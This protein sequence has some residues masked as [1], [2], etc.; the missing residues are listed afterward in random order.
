MLIDKQYQSIEED[1]HCLFSYANSACWNTIRGWEFSSTWVAA[2]HLVLTV[3]PEVWPVENHCYR[4]LWVVTTDF[5]LLFLHILSHNWCNG[6]DF[7][8]FLE[9]N[10]AH[11]IQNTLY[12]NSQLRKYNICYNFSYAL[13]SSYLMVEMR[14]KWDWF[15]FYWPN[16]CHP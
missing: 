13:F 9:Y 2:C 6:W 3:G 1:P 4:A 16:L 10:C 15:S 8:C 7:I 14:R 11:Q 5:W 12:T